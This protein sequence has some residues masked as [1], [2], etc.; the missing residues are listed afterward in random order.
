MGNRTNLAD[1]VRT[2][3]AQ[4]PVRAG[5]LSVTH[6]IAA[7]AGGTGVQSVSDKG[8]DGE[9]WALLRAGAHMDF[10]KYDF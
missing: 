2:I 7:T 4:H 8:L 1:R 3:T 5:D 6:T 10:E 9:F